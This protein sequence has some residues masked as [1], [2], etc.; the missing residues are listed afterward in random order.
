MWAYL[1]VL[2]LAAGQFAQSS[3]GELRIT[4]RDSAGL[5]VRCRVTVVS[6]ANDVSPVGG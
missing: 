1:A 5:S 6:E 4:V 2:L 3:A